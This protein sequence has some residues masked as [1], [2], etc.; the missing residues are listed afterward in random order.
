MCI[1]KSGRMIYTA[2]IPDSLN[3][4]SDHLTL[5]VHIEITNPDHLDSAI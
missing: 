1:S 5:D 3:Y 4:V 2:I